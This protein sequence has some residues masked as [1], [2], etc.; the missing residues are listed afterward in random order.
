MLHFTT[1]N[2]QFPNRIK[3]ALSTRTICLCV[4]SPELNHWSSSRHF[5]AGAP[6]HEE[7]AD[8]SHLNRSF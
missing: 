2:W 5:G 3:Q 1:I 7:L 8:F 4:S 6:F